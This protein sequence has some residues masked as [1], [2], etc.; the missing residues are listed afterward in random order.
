[1]REVTTAEEL[2]WAI[3][4]FEQEQ[5][6]LS[7]WTDPRFGGSP[8]EFGV[9][10]VPTG[11][12]VP[13]ADVPTVLAAFETPVSVASLADRGL[14]AVWSADSG[15]PEITAGVARRFEMQRDGLGTLAAELGLED[16]SRVVLVYRETRVFFTFA[17]LRECFR[18]F[19]PV[20]G[21]RLER[22]PDVEA[23]LVLL[24]GGARS[25]STL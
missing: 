6:P 24:T 17:T 23:R 12:R 18:R 14:I 21:W 20:I 5:L 3:L 13:F 15:S 16:A 19:A 11:R 1:M 7:R 10:F 9:L 22:D 8:E 4:M 2:I 25:E